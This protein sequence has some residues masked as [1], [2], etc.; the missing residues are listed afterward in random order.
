MRIFQLGRLRKV[1]GILVSAVSVCC[2]CAA[3]WLLAAVLSHPSRA[4]A[5]L[6]QVEQT[7]NSAEYVIADVNGNSRVLQSTVPV[8]TNELG[9]VSYQ[10]N[11]YT[12]L[13]TGMNYLSNGKWVPASDVIQI[14][15]G[16]GA[17]TNGQHQV[18]FAANINASNALQTITPD[19][20]QLNSHI[21]GLSY[22]DTATGSNVLFAEIQDST[23]QLVTSNQVV[24]PNAFTNCDADVR[25]TYTLDGIEQDIVVQKQLPSPSSFGLNP[26]TTWLQ[27]WTEFNNP[28]TPVIESS[29]DGGDEFLDFGVMKMGQGKAFIMG[30]DTNSVPVNKSWRTIAGRTFLVEQLQLDSISAQLQGLPSYSGGGNGTGGSGSEQIRFQGFPKRSAPKVNACQS[31]EPKTGAGRHTCPGKGLGASGLFTA[32]YDRKSDLEGKHNLL[33]VRQRQSVRHNHHRGRDRD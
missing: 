3:A 19:D 8:F 12:E 9:Q 21:M 10:T 2:L 30:N 24:Y 13:A 7:T 14:T 5:Q 26:E 22:Y 4:S 27:V 29:S 17:A 33:C 28:P 11:S 16:G 31:S 25:Y 6:L 18:F 15:Q 23:G 32:D 20:L 1:R